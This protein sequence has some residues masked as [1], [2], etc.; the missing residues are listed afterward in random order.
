MTEGTDLTWVMRFIQAACCTGKEFEEPSRRF[1]SE[2]ASRC[3]KL[4]I[5][6]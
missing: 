2:T 6:G 4:N 5:S 1:F 3:Q